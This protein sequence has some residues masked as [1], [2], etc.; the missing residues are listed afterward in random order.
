VAGARTE[1]GLV[2]YRFGAGLFYANASRF[3]EEVLELVD[4][5]EPPRWFV[6]LADGID[7]VDFTGGNTLVEL[8]GQLS[9]R[10][11]VFA[12]ATATGAVRS[13]LDRFGV[14]AVIGTDHIY[15]TLGDAIDAFRRS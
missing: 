13:E 11:V 12:V 7:D 4:G 6:L 9:A 10:N 2:V 14:T 8:A 15:E 3:T 1:P 5:P